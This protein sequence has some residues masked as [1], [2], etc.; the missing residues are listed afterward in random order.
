M[1]AIA[2]PAAV[3]ID[4]VVTPAGTSEAAKRSPIEC[5]KRIGGFK[6]RPSDVGISDDSLQCFYEKRPG[7]L[8]NGDVRVAV[9]WQEDTPEQRRRCT[10]RE[11]TMVDNTGGGPE[12]FNRRIKSPDGQASAAYYVT[13]GK[14]VKRKQAE[15]AAMKML[16]AAVEIAAPCVPEQEL[17][18]PDELACPL[19]IGDTFVRADWYGDDPPAIKPGLSEPTVD[20]Y[21]FECRYWFAFQDEGTSAHLSVRWAEGDPGDPVF[22]GFCRED[23]Y[24]SGD[25]TRVSDGIDPVRSLIINELAAA[26]GDAVLRQL[27]AAA[28]ARTVPC[29]SEPGSGVLTTELSPP[30]ALD[31]ELEAAIVAYGAAIAGYNERTDSIRAIDE[32][33]VSMAETAQRLLDDGDTERGEALF[34][35]ALRRASEAEEAQAENYAR[36]REDLVSLSFPP[37]TQALVDEIVER[38]AEL[39]ELWGERAAM[40]ADDEAGL[41]EIDAAIEAARDALTAAN[42]ALAGDDPPD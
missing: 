21:V 41:A 15:K 24:D 28:A 8:K 23:R 34:A 26:G 10:S 38:S 14:A 29:A 20:E 5:P 36:L 22:Q 11:L 40:D 18:P 4:D 27:A 6:N 2:V 7:D 13:E 1:L 25:L 31:A 33:A 35:Q 12:D 17:A 42:D 3:L 16:A 30:E 32:D 39:A 19:V 37:D 9:H